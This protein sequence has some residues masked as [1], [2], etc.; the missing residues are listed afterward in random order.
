MQLTRKHGL[1][2]LGL[3]VWNFITWGMF[4]KNLYSAHTSGESRPT[5]YWIAHT[6]LI[7]INLLLGGVLAAW[8]AKVLRSRD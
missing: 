2:L 7:V 8:G 1:F 3:S 4:T 5:G 6:M